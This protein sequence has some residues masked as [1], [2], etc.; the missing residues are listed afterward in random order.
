MNL[1][2]SQGSRD[3]VIG[4]QRGLQAESMLQRWSLN[5]QVTN[6]PPN[7]PELIDRTRVSFEMIR[8][9]KRYLSSWLKILKYGRNSKIFGLGC[10]HLHDVTTLLSRCERPS[11]TRISFFTC[12]IVT[13]YEHVVTPSLPKNHVFDPL[14]P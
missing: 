3:V 9:W 8:G 10:N 13:S 4:W 1:E 7:A 14:K 2:Y 6:T 11:W 5:L 12:H